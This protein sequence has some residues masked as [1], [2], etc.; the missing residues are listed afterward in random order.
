[1]HRTQ[2]LNPHKANQT[3]SSTDRPNV[4]RLHKEVQETFW[5]P[6]LGMDTDTFE[7]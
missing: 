3:N 5:S 1:M 7:V 6:E 2:C 4:G